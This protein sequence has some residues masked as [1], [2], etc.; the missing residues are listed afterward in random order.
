MVAGDLSYHA[1]C[2]LCA[3]CHALI[4][5]GDAYA[6]IDDTQLLWSVGFLPVFF[7]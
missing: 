3:A 5:P 4:R 2:F 6:L 7:V 1:A